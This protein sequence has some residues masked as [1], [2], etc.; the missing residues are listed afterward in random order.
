MFYDHMH[1]S[2][3][4]DHPHPKLSLSL[5]KWMEVGLIFNQLKG[6]M[7]RSKQVMFAY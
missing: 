4:L 3:H 7:A 1:A 6:N 5:Y 2:T